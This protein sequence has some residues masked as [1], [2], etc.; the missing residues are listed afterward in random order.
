MGSF[1]MERM[2]RQNAHEKAFEIQVLAQRMF[3]KQ[4]NKMVIDGRKVL[5]HDQDERINQLNQDLNIK[6]SK[7][8][9]AA[10]LR[11]MEE[12]DKCLKD[13]KTIMLGKL[14]EERE[15]NRDRYLET[16]KNLIL[17][18]MIKLLEPSLLIMCR[19]EDKDDIE[20]M[21]EDL[22]A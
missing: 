22:Q 15:N 13:I 18:S 2:L 1:E 17:Q 9:N 11:K 16:I 7:K 4:K 21:I 14:V 19:E 10:R 12:R 3:E 20:A 5:K 8:I 6:K